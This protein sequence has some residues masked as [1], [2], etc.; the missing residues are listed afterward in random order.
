MLVMAVGYPCPFDA[1][2]GNTVFTKEQVEKTANKR[3]K[4]DDNQPRK[5]NSV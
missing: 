3:D 5:G 4:Q 2:F 1:F